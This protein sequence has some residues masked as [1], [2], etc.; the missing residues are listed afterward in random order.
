MN[1]SLT[2]LIDS[3]QG[4]GARDQAQGEEAGQPDRRPAHRARHAGGP[5]R[6]QGA[7]ALAHRHAALR[8]AALLS[9]PQDCR[10]E[11]AHSRGDLIVVVIH[12]IFTH[13]N[14]SSRKN[15]IFGRFW[16]AAIEFDSKF[17]FNS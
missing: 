3:R 4:Q 12:G 1:N 14:F 2:D 16:T 13:T 11:C 17:E 8:A 9:Q 6:R 10:P 7:A 15:I 5:E